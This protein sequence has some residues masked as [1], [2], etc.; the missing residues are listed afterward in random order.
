[1]MNII[2][3]KNKV[4]IVLEYSPKVLDFGVIGK[5]DLEKLYLKVFLEDRVIMVEDIRSITFAIKEDKELLS[6]LEDD[7]V[8]E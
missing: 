1:M 2:K 3:T 7:E 8:K 4:K 6:Q 5:S